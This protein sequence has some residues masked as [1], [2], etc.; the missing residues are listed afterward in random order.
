MIVRGEDVHRRDMVVI[1]IAR[2]IYH[3]IG[4]V[5]LI[6]WHIVYPNPSLLETWNS[7]PNEL[8]GEGSSHDGS[9]LNFISAIHLHD[10]ASVESYL[11]LRAS[12][13]YL[14]GMPIIFGRVANAWVVDAEARATVSLVDEFSFTIIHLL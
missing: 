8:G 13:E 14:V 6:V 10:V 5:G 1:F 2:T 11:I 4:V 9:Q 3:G 7:L 12:M